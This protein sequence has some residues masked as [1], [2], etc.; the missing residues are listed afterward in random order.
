MSFVFVCA[1]LFLNGCAIQ[2]WKVSS[3]LETQQK[4]LGDETSKIQS[5]CGLYSCFVGSKWSRNTRME[6][7]F[8]IGNDKNSR[9]AEKKKTVCLNPATTTINSLPKKIR[10]TPWHD[11]LFHLGYAQCRACAFMKLDVQKKVLALLV[12]EALVGRPAHLEFRGALPR[13]R[14]REVARYGIQPLPTHPQIC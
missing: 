7:A 1:L 4:Y 6:E 9:G 5:W 10:R 12:T 13:K 2:T 14:L 8:P 3:P 11:G